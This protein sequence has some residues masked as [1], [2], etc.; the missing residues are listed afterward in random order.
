[1]Y[2]LKKYP[3]PNLTKTTKEEDDILFSIFY[4]IEEQSISYSPDEARVDYKKLTKDYY[5]RVRNALVGIGDNV[6][7]YGLINEVLRIEY[8]AKPRNNNNNNTN[9]YAPE[10]DEVIDYVLDDK[11][12]DLYYY[13]KK[14]N[15][16]REQ[17]EK[18][19]KNVY[20]TLHQ[21]THLPSNIIGKITEMNTGLKRTAPVKKRKTRKASRAA[22]KTRKARR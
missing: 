3:V 8:D 16:D 1:M 2:N 9:R 21:T 17:Q 13:Y 19:A 10:I 15:T 5:L 22:K 12:E 20:F 6:R 14:Y 11:K 7:I 18:R 4:A